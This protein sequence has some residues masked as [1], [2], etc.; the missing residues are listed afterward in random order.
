MQ[1]AWER[2]LRR[3]NSTPQGEAN[4]GNEADDIL[5]AGQ[6]LFMVFVPLNYCKCPVYLLGKYQ[7]GHFMG[8]SHF[9]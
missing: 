6:D 5:M 9:R 3:T 1:D 4:E 8:Q 2:R 7:P